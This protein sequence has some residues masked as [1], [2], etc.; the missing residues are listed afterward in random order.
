M[1]TLQILIVFSTLIIFGSL[2]A[3]ALSVR[4]LALNKGGKFPDRYVKVDKEYVLLSFSHIQPSEVILASAGEAVLP[5]FQPVTDPEGKVSY[6]VVEQVKLPAGAKGVLLLGWNGPKGPRYLAIDDD[7][8]S[9]KYDKWML[10]N[11]APKDVAFKIGDDNKSII[12]NSNSVKNYKLTAAENVG[13]SVV[14]KAKWGEKVKIFYSSYWPVRSGERG[15]VIF[16]SYRGDRVALRK[17]SDVL[18]KPKKKTE[19]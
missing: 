7:F 16:F 17:I 12:I 14:G 3:N 9:A 8:L 10:I 11:T 4:T 18:L 6:N 5:L 2:S 13:V 1:K 15:I 19:E